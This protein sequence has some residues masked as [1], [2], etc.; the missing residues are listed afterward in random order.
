MDPKVVIFSKIY[1]K[2]P[3]SARHEALHL[4]FEKVIKVTFVS[5]SLVCI[6]VWIEQIILLILGFGIFEKVHSR[7]K[8]WSFENELPFAM[9]I[10][11]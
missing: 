11:F 9:D 5:Q 8:I 3:P 7:P 2:K 6:P 1:E 4:N 10:H